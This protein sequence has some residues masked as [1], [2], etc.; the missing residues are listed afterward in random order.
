MQKLPIIAFAHTHWNSRWM[1][2][3]QLLSRLGSHGWPILYSNGVPYTWEWK[4]HIKNTGIHVKFEQKDNVHLINP[5]LC[6]PRTN[7]LKL[8]DRLAIKNHCNQLKK[9]LNIAKGNDF[10][11]ICFDPDFFPY[12]EELN[13]RYSLF[14]I[15]DVYDKIGEVSETFNQALKSMLNRVNLITGSSPQ[16]LDAV[17]SDYSAKSV[18]LL[19]AADTNSIIDAAPNHTDPEILKPISRPRIGYLGAI[20]KKMDFSKLLNAVRNNESW[21]WVFIGPVN[22]QEI[23]KGGDIEAFQEIYEQT[24]THFIGEIGRNDIPQFLLSMDVN[25]MCLKTDKESWAS[26]SYP[27]KI[28]EYLATGKPVVSSDLSAVK[29][30]CGNLIYYANTAEEWEKR[31]S[32]AI[33]EQCAELTS[34][35]IEFARQNNW[36][37]RVDKLE[38]LILNRLFNA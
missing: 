1:N 32:E 24:N 37:A 27:L 22:K 9:Y 15:Y 31:L 18:V 5:G 25:I 13:P 36:D 29:N 35:R 10:I 3:Q 16:V 33:R 28:N 20:N 12:L 4:R 8:L 7:R 17:V 23:E 21:Q 38:E 26:Y 6:L 30:E 2:R 14:H 19:N 11:V 34:A